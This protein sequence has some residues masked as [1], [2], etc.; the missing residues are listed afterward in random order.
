VQRRGLSIDGSTEFAHAVM[1]GSVEIRDKHSRIIS[2]SRSPMQVPEFW[3]RGRDKIAVTKA[4]TVVVDTHLYGSVAQKI[5]KRGNKNPPIFIFAAT[6]HTARAQADG[7]KRIGPFCI[8]GTA[9]VLLAMLSELDDNLARDVARLSLLRGSDSLTAPQTASD[10]CSVLGAEVVASIDGPK[11]AIFKLNGETFFADM[12]DV[13][14]IKNYKGAAD[15]LMA[16][17]LDTFLSNGGKHPS[18][19]AATDGLKLRNAELREALH[20][21]LDVHVGRALRARGATPGSVISFNET[22]EDWPLFWRHVFQR[23]VSLVV[24]ALV[25]IAIWVMFSR[26]MAYLG[27]DHYWRAPLKKIIQLL[28][29]F[30]RPLLTLLWPH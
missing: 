27:I 21:K 2:V 8:A 12:K 6:D 30:T 29:H 14:G 9:D 28:T 3:T 18:A 24:D 19:E 22:L 13:P 26:T 15:A 4:K 7:I 20:H 10:I 16:A 23:V 17:I 11:I 5:L 25:W 1:G